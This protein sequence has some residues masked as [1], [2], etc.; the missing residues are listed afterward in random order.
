MTESNPTS[1]RFVIQ[2]VEVWPIPSYRVVAYGDNMAPRHSNF[3]SSEFL[4]KTLRVAIPALDVSC[5]SMNP[6]GEG[7][8]SIVF[9]DGM[10]LDENQL[11]LLGLAS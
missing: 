3:S 10:D 11:S 5:L 7:H 4:L 9:V 1:Y 2:Q 6:L 8:G